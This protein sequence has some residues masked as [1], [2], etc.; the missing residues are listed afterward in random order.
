MPQHISVQEAVELIPDGATIMCGGFLGCGSAHKIL[1]A[2]SK[3]DKKN[4]TLI[5]N[6][7][8]LAT[9][10][11]GKPNY[12]VAKL[13][14]EHKV[15][16]LIATHVGLNPEVTEQMNTGEMTVDLL[17]Q[18]SLAEM[19]RA[20]GSGL[21]GVLTRTGLG[22]L[23]EETSPFVMKRQ[24]VDGVDYLLMR[25]LRAD[26]ALIHGSK[27]DESGNIWHE[28][29]TRNFN[30]VMAAAADIVIAE[31]VSLVKT[32]EIAPENVHTYGILVDYIVEGG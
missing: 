28:G 11:D 16:H 9:G 17:P 10:P 14:H 30:E 29:T 1:E 19:I 25:P 21:G 6:D 32:G 26:V 4:F 23:I 18:G 8:G 15:R 12:G 7:G 31:A 24:T 20:G 2:L 13:I 3:T 5:C 27:I 22:T